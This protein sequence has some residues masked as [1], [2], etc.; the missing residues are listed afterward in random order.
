MDISSRTPEGWP[1]Q[2][3]LCGQAITITPSPGTFDAPCPHCGHLLWFP[4][5]TRLPPLW[6]RDT[7]IDAAAYA[8]PSEIRIAPHVVRLIPAAMARENRI[9]PL[10]ESADALVIA[11]AVPIDI[12]TID[13]VQFILNRPV[14]VVPTNRDWIDK[15][16]DNYFGTSHNDADAP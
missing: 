2:C 5:P 7:N 3:P 1:N 6:T 13:K 4:D 14:M 9:F 16:H 12:E 15:Q 10:C 8:L 11:V